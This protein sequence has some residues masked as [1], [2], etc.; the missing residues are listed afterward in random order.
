MNTEN[1]YFDTK[2]DYSTVYR[3]DGFQKG[4]VLYHWNLFFLKLRNALYYL[5][6][7][8]PFILP[9]LCSRLNFHVE[10]PVLFVLCIRDNKVG[11]LANQR[12]VAF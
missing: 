10:F 5:C 3:H 12:P 9:P 7:S 8:V 11:K 2:Y 4:V 1:L 6:Y